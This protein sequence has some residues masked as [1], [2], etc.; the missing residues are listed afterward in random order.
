MVSN[1]PIGGRVAELDHDQSD[2]WASDG[3]NIC[4]QTLTSSPFTSPELSV[5]QYRAEQRM[6]PGVNGWLIPP[7]HIRSAARL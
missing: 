4:C 5:V 6:I 2:Y 1:Q 3:S 7:Y